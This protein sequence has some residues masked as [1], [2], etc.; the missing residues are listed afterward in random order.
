MT[1][2]LIPLAAPNPATND[3]EVTYGKAT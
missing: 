1:D 3:K 2:L